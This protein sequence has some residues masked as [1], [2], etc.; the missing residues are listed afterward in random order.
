MND[1]D[2]NNLERDLF[3]ADFIVAKTRG[4][5]YAQ[6]LYA[7]YV[8]MNFSRAILK[9]LGLVVGVMLVES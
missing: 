5:V 8:I 3:H 9:N 7:F 2:R 1:T 6:N 4:D